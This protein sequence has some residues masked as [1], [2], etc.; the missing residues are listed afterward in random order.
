MSLTKEEAVSLAKECFPNY[1]PRLVKAV[2]VGKHFTL[3]RFV[4]LTRPVTDLR[5][6]VDSKAVT[7]HH[8]PRPKKQY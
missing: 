2:S 4:I 7:I 1:K 3:Y 6:T 5:I 8:A